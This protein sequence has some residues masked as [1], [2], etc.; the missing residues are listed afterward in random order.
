LPHIAHHVIATHEHGQG[1]E[2]IDRCNLTVL[3]EPGQED[4]AD[5]LA[6]QQVRVVASLPCY[7]EKNVDT[8]R[9]RGVY[10][11]SVAGKEPLRPCAPPL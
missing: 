11:R 9:G 3:S 1:K 8:Q 5:F 2:V 7:S 6:Q 10:E 4:L